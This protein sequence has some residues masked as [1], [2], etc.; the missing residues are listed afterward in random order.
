MS[1]H[2]QLQQRAA[3]GRPIRVGLIGA[4][5]FGS[6]YLAQ[7]PRTPGVHLVAIADLNA[8][9]APAQPGARGLGRRSAAPPASVQALRDG[10]TWITDDWQ[11]L[12]RTR[13]RHRRRV[14]RRAGACGRPHPRGLRAAASM[15]S[16]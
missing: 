14:H 6:M 1:L 11:A 7:V 2:H 10:T 15:S 9:G 4:G 16:T 8:R 5:K 13:D 3:E 12:V